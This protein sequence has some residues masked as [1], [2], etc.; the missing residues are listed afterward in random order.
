M[1]QALTT[2]VC[3][4]GSSCRSSLYFFWRCT[5]WWWKVDIINFSLLFGLLFSAFQVLQILLSSSGDAVSWALNRCWA[6]GEAFSSIMC[7][8]VINFE[9]TCTYPRDVRIAP[10]Q[11]EGAVDLCGGCVAVQASLTQCGMHASIHCG[12]AVIS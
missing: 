2:C 1:C 5:N 6:A 8:C 4:V 11:F 7:V 3:V 12:R 9:K 10:R